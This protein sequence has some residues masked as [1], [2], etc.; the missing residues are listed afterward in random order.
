MKFDMTFFPSN[1]LRADMEKI[2]Q[3]EALG[4]DG[5]WTAEA[6]HNPFFPLTLGAKETNTIQLGTQIA[7]AF[8]RSPMVTAQIAWDLAQ[9]S[10]G[11]FI[12]GLGTQVR[13]H[14]T[15]RFSEEW[16]NPVSR[17]R[18]YIEGMRAIWDTFQ[19]DARLRYRGEHYTFRLMA[20]FFNPG[21][22]EHP[23][24]PIY[25]AGVNAKICRLAGELCDGLHAHGFHTISYMNEVVV[26]NIE[27]GLTESGR[28][29]DNFT[30]TIPLFIVTGT[31][32]EETRQAEIE[33]KTRIAFYGS[34]PSY[35]AVMEHHGWDEIR[36]KLSQM[37]RAGQWDTMWQEV[38]DDMLH[39]MAVVAEPDN[40]IEA[41]QERYTGIADRICLEWKAAN[42]ELM[43]TIAKQIRS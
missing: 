14:I 38:P 22:I 13:A 30:L 3:A 7:V 8:P 21:P 37:A 40:L 39:E 23:H 34:T 35:K 17:M 19:N 4:F 16:T 2:K 36:V 20:P 12:L 25:I 6:A 29:R 31:T 41:I 1:D 28:N 9:Q 18:E 33:A 32:L 5:A 26:A 24:I 11:R 10:N 27:K 42:I 15:R 43:E